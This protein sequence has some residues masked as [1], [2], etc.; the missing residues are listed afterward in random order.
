MNIA[1]I[2][3][4]GFIGSG[5]LKEA[6]ARDHRVTAL[7]S[8]PEKIAAAPG[9]KAV[10]IDVRDTAALAEQL[11]GHDAV[12]SAF[13]G[14]AQSDVYG[15]YLEGFRSILAATKQA[16]VARL[17]MVGGA[18]SLE[19]APGLQVLDTP[20]FPE[21]YKATA[22]GARQ[23]LQLLKQEKELDWTMLSPSAIIAPGQR[24]GKFRLGT[25]QLLI[26]QNGQSHISV[27]DYAAAMIDELERPAHS[28]QRFTA[29]Y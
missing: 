4:S 24:T 12:I 23:A 27:E 13:S 9:L 28:R 1:L 10:G 21:Q 19:V 3:A 20:D 29:G 18:G 16:G 7:V 22:E 14:H 11:R 15:Y 8:R 17:L 2:G 5:L 6:L 25:D 26:D